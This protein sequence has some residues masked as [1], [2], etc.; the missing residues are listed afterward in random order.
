M[1]K[2]VWHH[3]APTPMRGRAGQ[4]FVMEEVARHVKVVLDGQGG[5]EL[6]AG[7]SRFVLPY[8]VDRLLTE[9]Q[10]AQLLARFPRPR[11]VEAVRTATE[12]WREAL[13]SG[14]GREWIEDGEATLWRYQ[15]R[16]MEVSRGCGRMRPAL[17]G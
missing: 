8:L 10:A 4:W 15:R 7:Y 13:R 3:D 9:T 14:D 16:T 5:D 1:R 2:I 11:V 6:L 17:A 12:E